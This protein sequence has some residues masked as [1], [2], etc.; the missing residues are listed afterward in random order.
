[1]KIKL[2]P[3]VYYVAGLLSKTNEENNAIGIRTGIREVEERFVEIALKDF[4]IDPRK[5]LVEP[6]GNHNHVY[7]YH[8]QIAKQL[9]LLIKSESKIFK[10]K[11][12]K[13]EN[14][15][16]GMFDAAGH[17]GKNDFRIKGISPADAMMLESLGVHTKGDK[18]L[19]IANFI[20]LVKG[21]SIMVSRKLI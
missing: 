18:I 20:A 17:M 4:K 16:A 2:G 15:V 21:Q 9:K 5:I 3:E 8:S 11:D 12:T 13:S 19:N 10:K 7:F 14:Y 1:M 6:E